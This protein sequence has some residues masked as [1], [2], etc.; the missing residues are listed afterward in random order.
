MTSLIFG[1]IYLGHKGI[2]QHKREKQRVKN[3]QRW[4]GLRDEYDEQRRIG[5][6]TRSL[7]IQRTGTEIDQPSIEDRPIL[8]L[9]DQQEAN[10]ARTGWRPQESW[11]DPPPDN[12]R[13]SVEVTAGSNLRPVLK[14]KTGSTWDEGMP[15]RLPVS[16]RNWDEYK[17]S[18]LSGNV[19]RSG[20]VS[21]RAASGTP[22][23]TQSVSQS[24][25]SESKSPSPLPVQDFNRPLTTSTPSR[26]DEA[27]V[28]ENETPGGRMAELIELGNAINNSGSNS[29]LPN[30]NPT[31][32]P[33]RPNAH[34]YYSSPA[35]MYSPPSQT[36]YSQA[37]QTPFGVPSQTPF[38]QPTA[39]SPF[40]PIRQT[41]FPQ[42]QLSFQG[43]QQ[44]SY[45]VG[46]S[47]TPPVMPQPDGSMREWWNRG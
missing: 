21:N 24:P 27:D 38:G 17:P 41:N 42:H 4:E 5:R 6:E 32:P 20:S 47:A 43:Y 34:M 25:T 45:G 19:S 15:D 7:D 8:T 37:L 44:G 40:S 33:V 14:H 39:Q 18:N 9:R 31:S 16:R 1:S 12:R 35:T 36:P 29:P 13:A 11:N 28:I 30:S 3:Y 2:V 26:Q 10:D 23:R 22:V 46:P